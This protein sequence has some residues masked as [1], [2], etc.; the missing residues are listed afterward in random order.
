MRARGRILTMLAL[1]SIVVAPGAPASA[2]ST[3][4][5]PG[6][7]T[8]LAGPA[9]L[10]PAVDAVQCVVDR[11]RRR[12]HLPRL[13][14]NTRLSAAALG[15]GLD[16][17]HRHYF[18]HDTP[19]GGKMAGRVAATGYAARRAWSAGEVLATG[20]GPSTSPLSLVRSLLASP[21]HRRILLD[22][23]LRD[24]GTGLVWGTALTGG[25]RDGATLVLVLGR[26]G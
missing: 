10:R 4:R 21:P 24:V 2:A 9:G 1:G 6:A 18:A 7:T 23:A 8:P 15:H 16:M 22:P 5:C 11:E 25:R 17:V 14:R 13:R 20:S 26:R 19:E 12:R 3:D